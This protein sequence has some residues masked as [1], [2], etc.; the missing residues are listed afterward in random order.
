M[1]KQGVL[2]SDGVAGRPDAI[3]ELVLQ[4]RGCAK[5]SI[6]QFGGEAVQLC[7]FKLLRFESPSMPYRTI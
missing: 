2:C 4:A 7:L 5:P 1:P 6:R 3:Q